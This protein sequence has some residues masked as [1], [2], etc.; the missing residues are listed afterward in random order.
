[1]EVFGLL[2]APPTRILF[3]AGGWQFERDL[4]TRQTDTRSW[5]G[6]AIHLLRTERLRWMVYPVS[7]PWAADGGDFVPVQTVHYLDRKTILFDHLA[8][9]GQVQTRMWLDAATGMILRLQEYGGP[10]NTWLLADSI[11]TSFALDQAAP[12][13]QLNDAARS[14]DLPAPAQGF[15]PIQPTLTPA[16]TLTP[17]PPIAEELPPAGFDPAGSRLVFELDREA[18]RAVGSPSAATRA[19]ARSRQRYPP[20]AGAAIQTVCRWLLARAVDLRIAVGPALRPFPGWLL[21]GVQ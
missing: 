10:E 1:M 5:D 14:L 4:F 17:H 11:V 20:I 16:I 6:Y 9:N 18:L 2:A 21:A 7:S 19:S 12:P 3:T 8:A 13:G 15:E